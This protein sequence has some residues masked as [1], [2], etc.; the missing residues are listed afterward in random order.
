MPNIY[1]DILVPRQELY[2]G[3]K[4]YIWQYLF[5]PSRRYHGCYGGDRACIDGRS[6]ALVSPMRFEWMY[7]YM[8]IYLY[9]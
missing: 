1:L 5:P 8:H 7:E 6:A 2:F 9:A 3:I 4:Y